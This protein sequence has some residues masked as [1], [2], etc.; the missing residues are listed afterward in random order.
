[1]N[2]VDFFQNNGAGW[3]HARCSDCAGWN[4]DGLVNI[5]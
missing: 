5:H 4:D 1:M 3:K 2:V